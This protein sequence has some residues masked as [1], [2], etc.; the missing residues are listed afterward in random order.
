M[1]NSIYIILLIFIISNSCR[2]DNRNITTARS[3]YDSIQK[4]YSLDRAI[5]QPV[6][7][8]LAKIAVFM[9]NNPNAKIDTVSFKKYI[10]NAK[11]NSIQT[12]SKIEKINE[13]DEKINYK[14]KVLA[15]LMSINSFYNNELPEFIK[16]LNQDNKEKYIQAAKFIMPK[17][18]LI[19]QKEIEY[20]TAKDIFNSKYPIK[21]E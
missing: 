8:S 12:I 14:S 15:H 13:I 2:N 21:S 18:K 16:M 9:K 19:K 20:I 5:Q 7:D 10:E 4:E 11:L 6:L 3:F 1:R 17:L